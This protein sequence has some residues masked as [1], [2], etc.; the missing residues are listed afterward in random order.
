MRELQ[1]TIN[2]TPADMALFATPIDLGCLI[3]VNTLLV[4]VRY[5]LEVIGG[6]K[7]EDRF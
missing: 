3:S 7:L 1:D 4:R 5:E 6:A 2:A